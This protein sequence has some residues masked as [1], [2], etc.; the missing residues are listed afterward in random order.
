MKVY[1]TKPAPT[2]MRAK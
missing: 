2:Y 1:L